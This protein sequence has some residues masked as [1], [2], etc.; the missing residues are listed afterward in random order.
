MNKSPCLCP[1]PWSSVYVEMSGDFKPCCVA[2]ESF[3]A[4]K[5]SET[6]VKEFIQG[7]FMRHI[8]DQMLAGIWPIEC[9]RCERAEKLGAVSHRMGIIDRD[10]AAYAQLLTLGEAYEPALHS[11]DV[12]ISNECNFKCRS[13][14]AS[15]SSAWRDD[16]LALYPNAIASFD[17]NQNNGIQTIENETAFWEELSSQSCNGIKEWHFAGGEALMSA[18]HYRLLEELIAQDKVDSK[19]TYTTNLSL[20]RYKR[21]DAIE[22]LSHFAEVVFHVSLDGV[23]EKGEYIR[24]G[25]KWQKWLENVEQIGL[26]LPQAHID[27]HF[28]V[29]A[30]NVLDIVEHLQEIAKVPAFIDT[31]TGELKVGLTCLE[32]PA[33][34]SARVLP[35]SLKTRAIQRIEQ[36]LKQHAFGDGVS[37]ALQGVIALLEQPSTIAQQGREFLRATKLL[38]QRRNQ[39]FIETFPELKA[40]EEAVIEMQQQAVGA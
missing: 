22:L 38:D 21:W 40:L 31:E 12:R 26:H 14:S 7:D 2:E 19:I 32:S 27:M 30:F 3:T 17:L 29:S 13:C 24:R 34:L 16:H 36:F 8:R 15:F 6:T 11:I 25:L 39:D 4:Y 1:L 37:K 20:L 23:G 28:V 9:R 18:K 35:E 5:L 33:Y 10:N